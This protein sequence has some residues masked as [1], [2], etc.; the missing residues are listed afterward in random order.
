MPISWHPAY[1]YDRYWACCRILCSKSLCLKRI[2]KYEI[3]KE[4]TRGILAWYTYILTEVSWWCESQSFRY[5]KCAKN[6]YI[7]YYFF[8]GECTPYWLNFR[9]EGW[10]IKEYLGFASFKIIDIMYFF[11]RQCIQFFF[12]F[13]CDDPDFNSSF[14]WIKKLFLN[15][16]YKAVNKERKNTENSRH[17]KMSGF[18]DFSTIWTHFFNL[19]EC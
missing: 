7:C 15:N 5:S 13:L 12:E 6:K 19:K 1:W 16:I 2:T 11:I 9:M 8:L 14:I 10:Y 4:G 17:F 3:E 18:T